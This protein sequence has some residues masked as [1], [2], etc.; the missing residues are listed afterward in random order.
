MISYSTSCFFSVKDDMTR[1]ERR[2][3][4][5]LRMLHKV[6]MDGKMDWTQLYSYE[7]LL[8][9]LKVKW[10]T[11]FVV[12]RFIAFWL[13]FLHSFSLS[14]SLCCVVLV[15][16]LLSLLLHFTFLYIVFKRRYKSHRDLCTQKT[17]LWMI[18]SWFVCPFYE[19]PVFYSKFVSRNL[20][21]GLSISLKLRSELS[22]SNTF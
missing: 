21:S 5:K 13:F 9:H 17:Y 20:H 22:V 3:E 15:G 2:D 4:M 10:T 19:F 16:S 1:R 12:A 11:C 7:F 14:L 6:I 18:L 8:S